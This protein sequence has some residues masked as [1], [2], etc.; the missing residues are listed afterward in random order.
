MTIGEIARAFTEL[1]GE[2][3]ERFN[4]MAAAVYA[5]QRTHCAVYSRYCSNVLSP[6]SPT[7]SSPFRKEGLHAADRLSH[8]PHGVPFLPVEAFKFGPVTSLE[9]DRADLVFESSGTGR[10]APSR[11]YVHDR[12]IYERS[13]VTQ[14]ERVFGH[15]PFVIVAHLPHYAERSSLVYMV[16]HLIRTFGV[17]GS[18]FFVDDLEVLSSA[19]DVARSCSATLVLVGVAFSLLDLVER[20]RHPLPT[21]AF[22][23][24]TGGMKT[25]RRETAR[26]TLHER[27][28]E[29]FC[30]DRSRIRS[31]YG[32]CELLSQCYTTGEEVFYPPGW[33]RFD[34]LD[35]TDAASVMPEDKTG[36]LAVIDLANLHSCSFLLT[37]DRAVRRGDGFE[38]LGRLTGAELRGCNFLME[39]A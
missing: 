8:L 1:H 4:E 12:R 27:L 28:A 37:G 15:G 16:G 21:D 32:M 24:E 36:A 18:G 19:A 9:P 31:E 23:I 35:S 5:H 26:S 25:H 10:G 30:I 14:F 17:E 6:A 29:G 38:V 33:M 13:V 34:I 7:L 39:N 2:D 22:V 20:K 3:S 11:H